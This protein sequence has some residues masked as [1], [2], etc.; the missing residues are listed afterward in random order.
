MERPY[1]PLTF[2]CCCCCCFAFVF[3]FLFFLFFLYSFY[4]S[5]ILYSMFLVLLLLLFILLT[6]FDLVP[7]T[8]YIFFWPLYHTPTVRCLCGAYVKRARCCWPPSLCF[9][10][11]HCR[12][13]EGFFRERL[14]A[15]CSNR[16]DR[17]R[18]HF[19]RWGDGDR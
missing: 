9:V 11:L 6:V 18:S 2:C 17:F 5:F 19:E 1:Q 4:T 12:T 8:L 3:V 7:N 10:S 16:S 14:L 13:H 15:R